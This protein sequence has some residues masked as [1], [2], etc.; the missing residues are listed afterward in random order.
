MVRQALPSLRLYGVRPIFMQGFG[1]GGVFSKG[2]SMTHSVDLSD[3]ECALCELFSQESARTHEA[4]EFGQNRTTPRKPGEIA[5]DIM[6][7]KRAEAAVA[8]V[9]VREYG[10]HIPVNYD[11][12]PE[13][14]GDDADFTINGW[15]IDVKS[16]RNGRWAMYPVAK[17]ENRRRQGKLPDVILFCN[18]P[19]NRE[20][21]RPE[22][23]TIR[24]MGFTGINKLT[25]TRLN[26]GDYIPGTRMPLQTDNYAVDMNDLCDFDDSVTYM[27]KKK[28]G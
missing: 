16:S 23:R 1:C 19:W 7:G 6:I 26:R 3:Y 13:K 11:V 4:I 18:T 25:K 17:L 8:K 27:L 2:D 14:D 10:L 22:G 24:I 28:R 12:Y 5:R 9:L 20:A 15:A 21:D